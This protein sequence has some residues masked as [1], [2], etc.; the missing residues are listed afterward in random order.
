MS[1]SLKESR[2]KA[3]IQEF[4]NQYTIYGYFQTDKLIEAITDKYQPRDL[5]G[6]FVRPFV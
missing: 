2:I 3:K 4:K 6:V 1:I 5:P